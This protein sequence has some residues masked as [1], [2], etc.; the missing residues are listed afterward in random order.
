M[1]SRLLSVV[2][3]IAIAGALSAQESSTAKPPISSS[4]HKQ[5]SPSPQ[6][7]FV[8]YWTAEPG[9]HTE[10]ML[11]NNLD[12]GNLLVTPVLRLTDGR[13]ITL[14]PVSI[15]SGTVASLNLHDALMQSHP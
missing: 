2:V 10:L 5:I 6:E 14:S 4:H 15:A 12:S 9:W 1:L 8:P 3:S 11:R 7:Q 13:E